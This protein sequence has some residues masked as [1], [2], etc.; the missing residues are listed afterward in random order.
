VELGL[1]LGIAGGSFMY[2]RG[3]V[4]VHLYADSLYA[5][6]RFIVQLEGGSLCTDVG[7]FFVQL[8]LFFFGSAIML[9]LCTDSGGSLHSRGLDLRTA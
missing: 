7:R 4:F 1:L 6:A 9:V 3:L 5:G 8:G 2:S